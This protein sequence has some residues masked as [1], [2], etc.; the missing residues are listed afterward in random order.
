VV[1]IQLSTICWASWIVIIGSDKDKWVDNLMVGLVVV[2]VVRVHDDG[3][4][5]VINETD[6]HVGTEDSSGYGAPQKR[7][8]LRCH[9]LVQRHGFVGLGGADKGRAISF[10]RECVQREL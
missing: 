8:K 7:R 10:L 9:R 4:G 2:L 5:P 6:F 1:L 3:D